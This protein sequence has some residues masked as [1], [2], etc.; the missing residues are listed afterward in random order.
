[1]PRLDAGTE[2]AIDGYYAE[3]GLSARTAKW[4]NEPSITISAPYPLIR[5]RALA[6]V[7]EALA[8][9]FSI[10]MTMPEFRNGR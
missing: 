8:S 3:M 6:G 9:T 1:M 5:V 10:A 7:G 4:S 2:R